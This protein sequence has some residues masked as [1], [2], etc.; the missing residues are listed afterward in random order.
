MWVTYHILYYAGKEYPKVYN[1]M[2]KSEFF[3]K[4]KYQ[5]MQKEGKCHLG[6][7]QYPT[8]RSTPFMERLG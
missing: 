4:L 6:S 1:W 7:I 3:A 8:D 2:L 5:I